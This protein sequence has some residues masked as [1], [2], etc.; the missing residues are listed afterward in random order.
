MS[1]QITRR[2]VLKRGL[3]GAAGL[4]FLPAVIAACN[5]SPSPSPTATP[6]ATPTLAATPTPVPATPTPAPTPAD[7]LARKLNGTLT[8]ASNHTDPA[9][10]AGMAAIDAAFTAVTG[11]TPTVNNADHNVFADQ[12]NF[13]IG[14]DANDVF[15]WYSGFRMQILAEKGQVSP[16]DD[17]WAA[18]SAN[19]TAA[20][21]RTV[22]GNDGHVYGIPVDY[23]PW[24][25]FYRKSVWAAKGY[26]VPE[27]WIEFLALCA[28]MKKDGLTPLA[29]GDQG[30]WPAMGWFD[31]LNLRLN[32]YDF[33]V[34]L[35]T[36]QA[37]WTDA[38]VTAV[39][40]AW[41][42]LIPFY[43]ADFVTLTW[44]KECDTLVSKK[45][46]MFFVGLFLTGE[47]STVDKT[48]A[49]LADID[50]FAFP[51]F[52][53]EFDAEKA[54]DAPVDIWMMTPTSPTLPAD[55][56]NARAYLEFWAKGSTQVLMYKNQPGLIPA[57]SDADPSSFDALTKRAVSIV[58]QA[59]RIT[60]FMDRDTRPDFAGTNGAQ[61]FLLTFLNH[62]SQDLAR[63][64]QSIQDF[65]DKLPAYGG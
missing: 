30:G 41:R 54:L 1:G 43:P 4:T 36:G 47:V 5:S 11:V 60:H 39:F 16:I 20:F 49:I 28:Q 44:Q 22:T 52:G 9:E 37:K 62:P 10:V 56:D 50:F 25:V 17:V 6:V 21:A 18:V 46:G 65:W 53:N 29:F 13:Y 51:Y 59:Q 24:C 57:A 8:V 33:H 63:F 58:G 12:I 14:P 38:R 64:Q 31:I 40:E 34:A 15:T 48:G 2:E 42:K 61:A 26:T 7:F 19:Y 32:G 35:L 27:T 23:Y 3:V 45:A 55:L